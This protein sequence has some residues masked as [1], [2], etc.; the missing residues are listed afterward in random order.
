MKKS[1]H[2]YSLADRLKAWLTHRH[3]PFFAALLSM[4]GAGVPAWQAGR[5]NIIEAVS[6]E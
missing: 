6:D 2:H 4:L 3:L 5:V 1:G